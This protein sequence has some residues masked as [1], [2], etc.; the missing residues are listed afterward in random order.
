MRLT[1][2]GLREMVTTLARPTGADSMRAM[3]GGGRSPYGQTPHM[4]LILT[5]FCNNIMSP[6]LHLDV[7]YSG[8]TI[9]AVSYYV[10]MWVV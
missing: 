8:S 1:S 10:Y 3:G 6:V 5:N 2:T 4:R 7:W 9:M